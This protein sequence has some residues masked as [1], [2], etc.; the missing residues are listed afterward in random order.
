ML[1][2]GA[3]H[4][5][6]HSGC[7]DRGRD[8]AS[9]STLALQLWK[10]NRDRR[11]VESTVESRS[12]RRDDDDDDDDDDDAS[13]EARFRTSNGS[14]G[15]PPRSAWTRPVHDA[16]DG[17]AYAGDRPATVLRLVV[18]MHDQCVAVARLGC[19]TW[20][21]DCQDFCHPV[22]ETVA[23]FLETGKWCKPF[24]RDLEGT[25]LHGRSNPDR[26]LCLDALCRF[27]RD[28]CKYGDD[29]KLKS[30][31]DG[32]QESERRPRTSTLQLATLLHELWYTRT[33]TLRFLLHLESRSPAGRLSKPLA[34]AKT[35]LQSAHD[36]RVRELRARLPFCARELAGAFFFPAPFDWLEEDATPPDERDAA[37]TLALELLPIGPVDEAS[38]DAEALERFATLLKETGSEPATRKRDGRCRRADDDVDVD[39]L[40]TAAEAY[41]V[42]VEKSMRERGADDR[43]R[44]TRYSLERNRPSAFLP[45]ALLRPRNRMGIFVL[46]DLLV[47]AERPAERGRD[48]GSRET[49]L[50]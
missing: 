33:G 11:T 8:E 25:D 31:E 42:A 9:R 38:L 46:E 7:R 43:L 3:A 45:R 13:S 24:R 37:L 40:Q 10:R 36:R 29:Q 50:S 47:R 16:T 2:D 35:A 41:C 28:A 30:G 20:R 27:G 49:A 39:A 44:R 34:D 23:Q 22:A 6:S 5:F 32:E 48:R 1:E 14:D 26:A 19:E 4:R 21:T 12:T 15:K 17:L 18:A